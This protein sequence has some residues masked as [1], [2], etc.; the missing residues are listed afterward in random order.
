M[1]IIWK[2]DIASDT[3][4]LPMKLEHIVLSKQVK[5]HFGSW[6]KT[7]QVTYSD[8]IDNE[9][10]ILPLYLS[11]TFLLPIDLLY[12]ARLEANNL[13]IGPVIGFLLSNKK[14]KL[15]LL[16]EDFEDYLHNYSEIGGL[17]FVFSSDSVNKKNHTISGYYYDP[18]DGLE[19]WK[20]GIFPYPAS[21]YRRTLIRNKLND[22]FN[23][24]I[25]KEHFFNDKYYN[26][27][28][29]HELL[30]NHNSIQKYLP[31]TRL[32]TN[33]QILINMLNKYNSV[34]LKPTRGSRG[35]GIVKIVKTQDGYDCIERSGKILLFQTK[36]DVTQYLYQN[37]REGK[38]IV[39]Q[40]VGFQK[41]KR[42]ID[43]RLMVQKNSLKKWELTAFIAR[44]GLKNKIYTNNPSE[45]NQG[46]EALQKMF[47]LSNEALTRKVQEIIFMSMAIGN[48][49]DQY[50]HYADLGI[51]IAIDQN[52]NIWI[53][54][55][56][57]IFQGHDMAAYVGD[58]F[59]TY[60]RVLSTLL[61]YLKTL[62]G[63]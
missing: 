38:Y 16:L 48:I 51:D 57:H 40:D 35:Y 22:H 29:L 45:V 4:T 60:K 54:E 5:L 2:K 30:K 41:G 49:F 26:K 7:L 28:K 58:D 43:F 50:G 21:M 14:E 33:N 23:V 62:A 8:E 6:N 34:Y 10:I 61:G 37:I 3:V 12:E 20:S 55:V 52:M 39:Q 46:I 42:N 63:F 13:F 59:K 27:S 11:D 56:N 44:Y 1:K 53:L 25:G 18:S 17:I 24:V 36:K 9:S 32:L 31:E 15:E 47:E 19:I